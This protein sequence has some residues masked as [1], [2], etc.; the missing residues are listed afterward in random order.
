MKNVACFAA[1]L[2]LVASLAMAGGQDHPK[3]YFDFG[4]GGNGYGGIWQ[5]Q[6]GEWLQLTQDN[7]TCMKVFGRGLLAGF[8]DNGIWYYDGRCNNIDCYTDWKQISTTTS[9]CEN[10]EVR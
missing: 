2:V 4:P 8:G 6:D 10:L 5:Y 9:P 7:P 1:T 3:A